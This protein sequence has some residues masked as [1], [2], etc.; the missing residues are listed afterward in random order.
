MGGSAVSGTSKVVSQVMAV[1][2]TRNQILGG[3]LVVE[4]VVGV[5]GEEVPEQLEYLL[6]VADKATVVA[7]A[8]VVVVAAVAVARV[9]LEGSEAV[10]VDYTGRTC[11]EY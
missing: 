1:F 5:V 6:L 8:E 10:A 3:C 7:V 2:E 4:A 11:P 9:C